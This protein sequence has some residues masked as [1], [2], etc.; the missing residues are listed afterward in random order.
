MWSVNHRTERLER[1]VLLNGRVTETDAW[2]GFSG[3]IAGMHADSFAIRAKAGAVHLVRAGDPT[4]QQGYPFALA[5]PRAFY[6]ATGVVHMT[7]T[8]VDPPVGL[9]P[10]FIW[11]RMPNSPYLHAAS[12]NGFGISPQPRLLPVEPIVE[13][14]VTGPFEVLPLWVGNTLVRKQDG[15]IS[16]AV[17]PRERVARV[18]TGFVGLREANDFVRLVPR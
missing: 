13:P 18:S 3:G 12:T 6:V 1:R 15:Q 7:S 8:P 11:A 16:A 10:D 14:L 2:D 17:W 5:P 9:E 4:S